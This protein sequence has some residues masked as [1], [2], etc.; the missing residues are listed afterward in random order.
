MEGIRSLHT[1]VLAV[2]VGA[3]SLAKASHIVGVG[4]VTGFLILRVVAQFAVFQG[5]LLTLRLRLA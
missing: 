1:L 2:L 4:F 3:N 5:F